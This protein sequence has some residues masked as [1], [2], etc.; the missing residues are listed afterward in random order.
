M[1]R[2]NVARSPET[3]VYREVL[4]DALKAA[5]QHK[6]FWPLAFVAAILFTAG[7]YDVFFR[8]VN[9]TAMQSL[10]MSTNQSR[11]TDFGA[12]L[13][14]AW[15]QHGNT[16]G[17]IYGLQIILIIAIIGVAILGFACMCQGALVFALGISNRGEEP[18]LGVSLK[19]GAAA[20]WPIAALNALSL[21]VIW[22][23]RFFAVL[24][25]ALL[26]NTTPSRGTWILTLV[27]FIIF[28]G[29]QFVVMII[30]GFALNAII[31]QGAAPAEALRRGYEIFK[32]HWVVAVET[33]V[34]L[35]AIAA[36]G[37]ITFFG[38]MFVLSIPLVLAIIAS[39]MLNSASLYYGAVSVFTVSII[40][41]AVSSISF[42]V[43]LQYATWTYLYR[44]LGEGGAVPK[45]H[46]IYRLLTG[47]YP[48][49]R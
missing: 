14:N 47:S 49:Q 2:T 22:I 7:G 13:M 29:L 44:R 36:L 21:S 5:W 18:K 27:S 24:P 16:F 6:H 26:I 3:P 28:F 32:R 17:M 38:L 11:F 33:T 35:A 46:R 12:Q 48:I 34:I 25:L 9:T 19:V 8:A 30:Q 37:V 40:L 45:I 39:A 43:Q 20:F 31:L 1:L 41:L 15:S 23:L 42:L 4:H 10:A